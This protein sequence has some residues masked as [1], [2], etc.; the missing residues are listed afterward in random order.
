[1]PRRSEMSNQFFLQSKPTMIR[2]NSKRMSPPCL[3]S[4]ASCSAAPDR[5]AAKL[6]RVNPPG[7]IDTSP[8]GAGDGAFYLLTPGH[9]PKYPPGTIDRGYVKS[10]DACPVES[11][12]AT[13]FI[14]DIKY[15]S[16]GT[17]EAVVAVRAQTEVH[18]VEDRRRSGDLAE[19]QGVLSG[20]AV[21]SAPSTGMA[22]ICSGAEVHAE[23][24]F[25]RRWVR[26]RSGSPAGATRSSV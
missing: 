10:F 25:L 18:E 24:S 21:R 15:S 5:P 4:A 22:W 3:N 1:M 7:G 13:V 23:D 9:N 12:E 2:G 17:R 20:R 8:F 6:V 16:P 19:D 14:G 26:F 11:G